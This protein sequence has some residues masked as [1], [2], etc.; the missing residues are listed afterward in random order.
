M[1]ACASFVS[2]VVRLGAMSVAFGSGIVS[3]GGLQY[4]QLP[5][6][7]RPSAHP[8]AVDALVDALDEQ[9]E[10]DKSFAEMFDP[11]QSKVQC[12]FAFEVAGCSVRT[13]RSDKGGR[14]Q[15]SNKKKNPVKCTHTVDSLCTRFGRAKV[16]AT[17]RASPAGQ[18][19]RASSMCCRR[20]YD[21]FEKMMA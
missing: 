1:R 19:M 10:E 21:M 13:G 3:A 20:C 7:A 5:P 4:R 6:V 8:A 2:L 9:Y 11:A 14:V 16:E 18:Q 17:L 12:A 15:S